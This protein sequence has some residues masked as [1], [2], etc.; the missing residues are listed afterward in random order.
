[1]ATINRFEEIQ[2]WR[3]ARELAKAIYR[4]SEQG[5]FGRDFGL[6]DQ[7]RRASVSVLSNIAEG[8]DRGGTKEFVHFLYVAKGSLAEVRAQ[9]YVALDQDYVGQTLFDELYELA[10]ETSRLIN[11]LIEYLKGT[12]LRGYKHRPTRSNEQ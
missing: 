10:D 5:R 6:R 2:G 7:I 4:A 3:K 12:S 11:G 1:M 9:L 8:F